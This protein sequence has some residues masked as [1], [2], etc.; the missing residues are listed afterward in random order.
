MNFF[1]KIAT[2]LLIA[3]WLTYIAYIYYKNIADY[4][5][6]FSLDYFY[7]VVIA[8]IGIF[9]TLALI[10]RAIVNKKTL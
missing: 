7:L 6:G 9:Y 5:F 2:D 3:M 1:E 4:I 10:W 8:V